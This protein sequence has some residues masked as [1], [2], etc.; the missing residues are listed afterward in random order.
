MR[1]KNALKITVRR[2]HKNDTHG[3]VYGVLAE[4]VTFIIKLKISIYCNENTIF[5]KAVLCVHIQQLHFSN[6][7]RLLFLDGAK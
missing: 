5:T 1:A 2:I 7:G 6:L 3:C 4:N